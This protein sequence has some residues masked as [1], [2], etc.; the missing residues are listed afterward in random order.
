MEITTTYVGKTHKCANVKGTTD[1]EAALAAVMEHFNE[2]P[3]RLFGWNVRAFPEDM[4]VDGITVD[5]YI[6]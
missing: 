2:T 5:L 1:K 4:E 3:V 6:D